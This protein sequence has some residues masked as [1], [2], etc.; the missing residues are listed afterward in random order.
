VTDAE[1]QACADP[2]PMLE[3][4]R[5]KASARKLRLFAV[6]CCRRVGHLLRDERS[7]RAVEVTE[8]SAD[9]QATED[10]LRAA[11]V[12]ARLV[13][14]G[15]GEEVGWGPIIE[16]AVLRAQE[17]A[18]W[19]CEEWPAWEAPRRALE[20]EELEAAAR[21]ERG[22]WQAWNDAR[23][24]REQMPEAEWQALMVQRAQEW[25]AEQ[26]G[27]QSARDSARSAARRAQADLLR[28]LFGPSFPPLAAAASWLAW[29]GATVLRVAREIYDE[30]AFARLPVLG[31]AL[32][33]A[34]CDHADLLAHCRSPRPHVRGCWVL[35]LLLGK[36]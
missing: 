19:A 34:G 12:E 23:K 6:A 18:A 11:A 3:F 1:W 9:G 28:E 15:L 31:D 32:E 4:L 26:Q 14:E 33:D 35:D 24:A 17:A 20:A 5:G 8:R 2:E 27:V 7:R 10:E 16:I 13:V 21:A 30:K 22:A 25:G 29:N 36:G